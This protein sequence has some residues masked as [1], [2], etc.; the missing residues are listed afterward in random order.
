MVHRRRHYD[1]GEI[2]MMGA[3]PVETQSLL[4]LVVQNPARADG[5]VPCGSAL[6]GVQQLAL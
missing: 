5:P 4:G 3:T 2:L 6:S 1:C